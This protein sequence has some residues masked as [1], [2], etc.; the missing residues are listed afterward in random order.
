MSEQFA[1]I[2]GSGFESF[3][4][5]GEVRHINTRFGEP[6]GPVRPVDGILLPAGDAWRA[7]WKKMILRILLNAEPAK[8]L[9][10]DSINSTIIE[11]QLSHKSSTPLRRLPTKLIFW[12]DRASSIAAI[13]PTEPLAPITVSCFWLIVSPK[14]SLILSA[15]ERAVKLLPVVNLKRSLLISV[16]AREITE[17]NAPKPITSTFSSSATCR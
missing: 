5:S 15:V 11:A 4:A 13:L 3:V 17:V 14:Q 10:P 12:K 2:V 9:A 8:P 7:A 1:I 16:P 6:S